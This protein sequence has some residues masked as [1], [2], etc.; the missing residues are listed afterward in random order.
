MDSKIFAAVCLSF[1]LCLPL[2]ACVNRDSD[3][4]PH[5]RGAGN[6][7]VGYW[8][9]THVTADNTP[10]IL[11]A[12]DFL[13]QDLAE[14]KYEARERNHLASVDDPVSTPQ[15]HV[16]DHKGTPRDDTWLPTHYQLWQ[17]MD[18]KG[19]VKLKHYYTVPY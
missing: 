4:V 2:G 17:C 11:K 18:A 15:G 7:P 6:N 8:F 12:Q 1:V 16:V 5:D 10:D 13:E 3:D 19:W 14:C 9:P